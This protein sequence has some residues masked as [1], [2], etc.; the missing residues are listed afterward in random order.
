[1]FSEFIFYQGPGEEEVMKKRM[2]DGESIEETQAD[3]LR[4]GRF[5]RHP[6]L[7]LCHSYPNTCTLSSQR[8]SAILWKHLHCTLSLHIIKITDSM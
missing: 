8:M 4:G 1:L 5:L 3:C 2:S 7:L 6:S